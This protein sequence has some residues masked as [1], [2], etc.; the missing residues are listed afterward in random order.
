MFAALGS[1]GAQRPVPMLLDE[2][3]KSLSPVRP[4]SQGHAKESG[5]SLCYR[6]HRMC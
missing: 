5:W 3:T 2:G 6:A 4:A 1:M